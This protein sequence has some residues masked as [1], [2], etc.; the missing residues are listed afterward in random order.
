MQRHAD[1]TVWH[2]QALHPW[3]TMRMQPP[4]QQGSLTHRSMYAGGCKVKHVKQP[5]GVRQCCQSL[6]AAGH[7]HSKLHVQVKG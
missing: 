3:N 6:G 7:V 5:L 1:G 2:M 4:C